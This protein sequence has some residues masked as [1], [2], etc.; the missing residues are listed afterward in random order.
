MAAFPALSLTAEGKILLVFRRAPDS[1][2]LLG[3]SY[4]AAKLERDLG[5]QLFHWDPRSQLVSI[6]FDESLKVVREATGLSVDPQAADQDASLLLLGDGSLLLTSFSWYAMPPA[7]AALAKAWGG[8]AFG[9][10]DNT[11]CC[12]LPWGTYTRRSEDHGANWS[13]RQYLPAWPNA[14]D[15]VPGLRSAHGGG[16]RG[17]AL[18]IDQEVVLP[19][20]AVR[21]ELSPTHAA[22]LYASPDGGVTWQYRAPIAWD[23]QGELAFYE[24][25]LSRCEDGTVVAWIRTSDSQDRI[26]TT[27]SHDGGHTWQPYELTSIVGHPAFA[28]GLRDGR[29][30]LIY[31]YRHYGYGVR[32]RLLNHSASDFDDAQEFIIREDGQDADLGYP[33]AVELSDGRVL[34]SYYFAEEDGCRH[35]AY[36][37][38]GT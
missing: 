26:A 33:W 36:S 32:A 28:L 30:L 24:P 23:P 16:S 37:I 34:V 22:H 7:F 38:L 21:E 5:E 2:W 1:R 20:Y 4:D 10:P 18:E 11:G 8:R 3:S 6:A 14:P 17:Q 27:R 9:G 13:E 15:L 25:T 35:I 19:S 29:T 12:Y 31:G